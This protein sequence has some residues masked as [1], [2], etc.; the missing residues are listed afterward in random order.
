MT[1]AAMRIMTF[2]RKKKGKKKK[3]NAE[4][5]K[6][7]V[8]EKKNRPFCEV[9]VAFSPYVYRQR[10]EAKGVYIMRRFERRDLD[11]LHDLDILK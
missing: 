11:I 1:T 5:K 2:C 7:N 10:G 9:N 8:E 6:E 3:V 4:L